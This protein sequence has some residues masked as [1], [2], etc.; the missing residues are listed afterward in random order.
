MTPVELA[1]AVY[2]KEP[3]ARSFKEDLEAH[4]LDP[5]GIV[6]STPSLFLMAR[7][8]LHYHEYRYVTN[9]HIRYAN[10]DCWHLYLY[11]GDLMSAFKQATHKLPYVSYERK[12][13][14]R[15]YSWDAIYTACAKSSSP[16]YRTSVT[17]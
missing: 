10:G 1:A 7:P 3:C 14:L 5:N 15:V 6:I 8:V 2:D 11:A 4:L 16:S 13:S 9:P 12:N 17:S